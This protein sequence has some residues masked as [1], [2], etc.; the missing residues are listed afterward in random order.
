[1]QTFAEDRPEPIGTSALGAEARREQRAVDL[2]EVVTGLA[3]GRADHQ[4]HAPERLRTPVELGNLVDD[5]LRDGS[6]VGCDGVLDGR[7][8]R[9]RGERQ[10]ENSAAVSG[11][12]LKCRTQ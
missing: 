1:L 11:R 3:D 9:V 12:H 5:G 8:L 4:P 10:N 6:P 2:R 7:P